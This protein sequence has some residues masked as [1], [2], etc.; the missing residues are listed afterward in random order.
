MPSV[1]LA[2]L[3]SELTLDKYCHLQKPATYHVSKTMF[4]IEIQQKGG[5][6]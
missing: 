6:D 1:K 2:S 3:N 4:H 5:G